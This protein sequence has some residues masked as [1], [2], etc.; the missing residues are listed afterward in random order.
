MDSQTP[1]TPPSASSAAQQPRGSVSPPEQQQQLRSS[2]TLHH[3]HHHHHHQ[4]SQHHH[5]HHIPRHHRHG[6]HSVHHDKAPAGASAIAPLSAI[7]ASSTAPLTKSTSI[8][9]S[10]TWAIGTDPTSARSTPALP[11]AP[12]SSAVDSPAVAVPITAAA[13]QHERELNQQRQAALQ[14]HLT[15]LLSQTHSVTRQL[16]ETYYHLLERNSR[17]ASTTSSLREVLSLATQ[18]HENFS[19]SASALTSSTQAR[20]DKFHS[21][22][23]KQ[24]K[25][26]DQLQQRVN[27]A[28]SRADGQAQRV[29]IVREAV[30][31]WERQDGEWALAFGRRLRMLWGAMA[32]LVVLLVALIVLHYMPAHV[33]PLATGSLARRLGTGNNATTLNVNVSGGIAETTRSGVLSGLSLRLTNKNDDENDDDDDDRLRLFDE[34]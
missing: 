19:S 31:D 16:D 1:K 7:T 30:A 27:D 11:D 4:H 12:Q 22:L 17:L 14:E 23:Q 13:I 21:G 34:L 26:I 33:D 5:H 2:E 32:T 9:K 20:I 24:T 6:N 8:A 28:R 18:L 10:K 29:A 15:D 25:Q 3:H